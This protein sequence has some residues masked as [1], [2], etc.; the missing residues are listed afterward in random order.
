MG[1]TV[2]YGD[3]SFED[4]LSI[5]TVPPVFCREMVRVSNFAFIDPDRGRM[6]R[7][8]CPL[9]K[10]SA[11]PEDLQGHLRRGRRQSRLRR[12]QRRQ[13]RP[14]APPHI[15]IRRVAEGYL[16]R[17]EPR[18]HPVCHSEGKVARRADPGQGRAPLLPHKLLR[19]AVKR[20]P[21]PVRPYGREV[22]R[23]LHGGDRNQANPSQGSMPEA[24]IA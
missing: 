14:V 23:G 13:E 2:S 15:R 9:H 20:K 18:V 16:L 21:N 24:V 6:R 11:R 17:E 7:R 5:R 19:E 1:I 4:T 8:E 3:A 10:E 12:L 22:R